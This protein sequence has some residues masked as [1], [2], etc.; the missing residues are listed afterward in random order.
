MS[1][2]I[3]TP[4]G[5]F[6]LVLFC[7]DSREDSLLTSVYHCQATHTAPA[8]NG[9]LGRRVLCVADG[10]DVNSRAG[11]QHVP[12]VEHY[13]TVYERVLSTLRLFKVLPVIRDTRQEKTA[14]L[15]YFII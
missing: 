6:R 15:Y 4:S 13:V 8:H 10:S 11:W 7:F 2:Q 12:V 1:V 5:S 3:F 9:I 14:K